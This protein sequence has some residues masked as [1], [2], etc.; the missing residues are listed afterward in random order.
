MI[1]YWSLNNDVKD[2]SG[3]GYHGT[4]NGAVSKGDYYSFNDN[5]NII[6]PTLPLLSQFTILVKVKRTANTNWDGL[7]G[8]EGSICHFQ[9]EASGRMNCYLYSGVGLGLNTGTNYITADGNWH[10]ATLTYDGTNIT[11]YKDNILDATIAD[12]TPGGTIAST[13]TWRIGMSHDTT[14]YLNGNIDYAKMFNRALT[15][16]EIAIEYNTMVNNEVQIHDSGKLYAKSMK[17][18]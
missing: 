10:L 13:D 3:N 8:T 17:Q 5:S 14:R 16:E 18:Y 12:P 7:F 15:A 4:N 11:L 2:Y 6:L 9:L 1:G